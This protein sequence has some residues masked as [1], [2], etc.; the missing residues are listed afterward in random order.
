VRRYNCVLQATPPY[1]CCSKHCMIIGPLV[2]FLSVRI[3]QYWVAQHHYL[4]MLYCACMG[5]GN[6]Q[7]FVICSSIHPSAH[8]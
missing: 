8:A 6:D 4:H 1:H 2:F 7:I 3:L 5:E